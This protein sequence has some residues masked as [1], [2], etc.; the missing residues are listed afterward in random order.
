MAQA[1]R[2][3]DLAQRFIEQTRAEPA[4]FAREALNHKVLP[5]ESSLAEDPARSWE[6][7]QFQIDI[8]EAMADVWRKKNG[9][10]T[11]INHEGRNYITVRSGHGPGKT[12][13]AALGA[14]WF[15]TAF[16]GRVVC[17][18]PKLAQLRTRLWSSIRKIDNRAEPWYRSTHVI[19]DTAVYW[20][21]PDESGKLYEDKNANNGGE[22]NQP[23]RYPTELSRH[24]RHLSAHHIYSAIIGD[25]TSRRGLGCNSCC[26]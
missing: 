2:N 18:A 15:N 8:L 5:G 4:W 11:R 16:M 19:H 21:R 12:H 6:L 7:D 23:R 22:V 3:T 9:I 14:H 20:R 24:L 1:Q 25:E 10:P 13:L 26:R 17:T